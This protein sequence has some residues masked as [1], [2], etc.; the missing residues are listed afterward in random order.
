LLTGSGGQVSGR[1]LLAHD[2]ARR[3]AV[4]FAKMPELLR[5]GQA[6]GNQIMEWPVPS[7]QRSSVLIGFPSYVVL[8]QQQ[9]TDH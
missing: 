8:M 4:N 3:I 9:S 1:A 2:E 6:G 7:I 5:N